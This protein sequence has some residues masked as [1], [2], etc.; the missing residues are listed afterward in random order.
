MPPTLPL[1][2]A[3]T[4]TD[5][6]LYNYTHSLRINIGIKI[7]FLYSFQDKALHAHF[8]AVADNCPVPVILYSV[9]A[10]TGKAHKSSSLHI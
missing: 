7:Y 4:K 6:V 3:I 9:P 10:F 2:I 5:D 8:T 1:P